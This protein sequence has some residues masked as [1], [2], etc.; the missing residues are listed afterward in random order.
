MECLK[1]GFDRTRMVDETGKV[2]YWKSNAGEPE[3]F[4]L[5]IE[6]NNE[7]D[8]KKLWNKNF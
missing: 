5:S 1:R 2:G 4:K 6:W 8:N 7:N 3:E